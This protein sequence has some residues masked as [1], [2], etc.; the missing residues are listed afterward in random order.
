MIGIKDDVEMLHIEVISLKFPLEKYSRHYM[1]EELPMNIRLI[2][3]NLAQ[4]FV[5][6]ERKQMI[7]FD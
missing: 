6:L 5:F 7:Y 4:I 3:K 2:F 1:Y